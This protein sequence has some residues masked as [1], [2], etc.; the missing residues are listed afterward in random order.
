M[1][2]GIGQRQGSDPA[3]LW[4][5]SRLGATVP[6]RPLTWK[7]PN[8][9]GAAQKKKKKK[10]NRKKKKKERKTATNLRMVASVFPISSLISLSAALPLQKTY[11]TSNLLFLLLE[12]SA[13]LLPSLCLQISVQI[14]PQIRP[15]ALSPYKNVDCLLLPP[16]DPSSSSMTSVF[17]I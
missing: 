11:S 5:W 1:S 4:L 17:Y 14:F 15:F 16:Q 13:C 9:V 2:C 7:P 8:A 12:L 3:L 6:I 10:K